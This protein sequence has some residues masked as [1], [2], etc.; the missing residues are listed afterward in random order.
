[1]DAV[2]EWVGDFE[3]GKGHPYVGVVSGCVRNGDTIKASVKGTRARPYR[4]WVRFGNDPIEAAHCTCP[5]GAEG[6]CKHVAAVLMAHLDLPGRFVP[7][8][9]IDANLTARSKEELVAL[10]KCLLEQSPELEPLLARPLPGFSAPPNPMDYYF[11]ALTAVRRA[12]RYDDW[13]PHE[14]ATDLVEVVEYAGGFEM[15]GEPSPLVYVLISRVLQEELGNVR[16]A[17]VAA[18]LPR[19]IRERLQIEEQTGDSL[20]PPF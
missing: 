11:M 16:A 17:E 1:M 2:R 8:D 3:I 14:I 10:V 13:S 12:N 6:K 15:S 9:D 19:E 18:A 4:V 7:L 5:V 20:A